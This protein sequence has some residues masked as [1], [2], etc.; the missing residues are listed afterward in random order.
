MWL[1]HKI[2]GAYEEVAAL[3]ARGRMPAW[4]SSQAYLRPVG[5]R[6]SLYLAAKQTNQGE[7]WVCLLLLTSGTL[8]F[9]LRLTLFYL[10]NLGGKS[11][12]TSQPSL[13][14][15]PQPS[16]PHT[17]LHIGA[18]D[19]WTGT[20]QSPLL[21]GGW[22][23]RLVVWEEAVGALRTASIPGQQLDAVSWWGK[24]SGVSSRGQWCPS[25]INLV[26]LLGALLLLE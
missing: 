21:C 19:T 22:W 18:G 6:Q 25:Y 8:S 16:R 7:S 10:L 2:H 11:G 24:H 23:P 5:Q 1:V 12:L 4:G 13:Q 3:Q 9:F 17:R 26:T 20:T 14:L 15:A